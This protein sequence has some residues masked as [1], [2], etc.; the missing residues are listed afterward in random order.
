MNLSDLVNTEDTPPP[1]FVEMVEGRFA[2]AEQCVVDSAE[3]YALIATAPRRWWWSGSQMTRLEIKNKPGN[4]VC[5]FLCA[6]GRFAISYEQSEMID[7]EAV[8]GYWR[9]TEPE[10]LK[11]GRSAEV[12]WSTAGGQSFKV[13]GAVTVSRETAWQAIG[14]M[15]LYGGRDTSL[16]WKTA[17]E[18]LYLFDDDLELFP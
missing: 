12:D 3:L 10:K 4:E 6:S 8:V 7:G 1:F 5:I 14:G 16:S 11:E 13:P 15:F 18:L 2:L 9:L 17:E